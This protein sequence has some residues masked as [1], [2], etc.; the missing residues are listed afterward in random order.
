MFAFVLQLFV[1]PPEMDACCQTDLFLHRPPSP[2]YVPQKQ[3]QDVATEILD[4]ELFDFDTE[5]QPI[6][7][8]LVGRTIEQA[9]IEVLHEE[10][11]AEMKRQQQQIM[12]IREAELAELRRLELEDR[13]LTAE[14]ERRI[15]QDKI[16]QDL[17]R[18]MQERIT[19]SKLLQGRIDTLLPD[20]L[21]TVEN[22]KDEK[23]R[24]EFERQIAPWLAKEVAQEIGQMIDSKELLEGNVLKLTTFHL[25]N[26]LNPFQTLYVKYSF[27]RSAT[28]WV[29]RLRKWRSPWT[30]PKTRWTLKR[31]RRLKRANMLRRLSRQRKRRT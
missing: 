31:R 26:H 22:I 6:V 27:R 10:E 21:D 18:E 2:P 7:E 16:A 3:G 1:R 24:E 13:K 4:G 17:D 23:D 30:L 19:A 20:I 15:L 5:V 11:I 28:C 25:I 9:L 8:V 29:R 14:K 12:A